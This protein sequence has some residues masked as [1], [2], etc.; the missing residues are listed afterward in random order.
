MPQ[1]PAPNR[2]TIYD[3]AD[4]AGVAISTVSR[5]LNGSEEVS[6]ATRSRVRS[7]IRKLNFRPQRTARNLAQGSTTSVAVALP[8]ATSLFFVEML[9][10]VKDALRERDIDLLL[11][12]LGSGQPHAT[13]QRFLNRGAVDALLLM[14]MPIEGEFAEQLRAF[15]A[16]VV[17]LGAQAEGL[18]AYWWDDEDGAYRA[19]SFLIEQGHRQIGLIASHAWS[20]TSAPRL[21][22]Y[23]RALAEADIPFDPTLVVAGETTKHAGYSEEAGAE[24]MA[25]LLALD[26]RPT[27]VFASSD[28]QAF[29]AWAYARDQ[30]LIIPRDL[31]IVGYDDIKL[32]RFLDLTT[33]A[34]GMHRAGLLATERL[35]HRIG[36]TADDRVSVELPLSLVERGSTARAK[37]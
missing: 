24:A 18:D 11:C 26:H 8:S 4:E 19:V 13:L 25:H 21:V 3:V 35:L 31:S 6:D 17:L 10:G 27:G 2:P 7:A 32:S 20:A 12:N 37:A 1:R 23:K 14:G 16:P 36:S 33:V 9:K 28:V 30:G 15:P 34:Q 29:G 5:V 22:G